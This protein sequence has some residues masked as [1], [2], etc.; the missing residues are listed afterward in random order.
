MY[1]KK[2][3]YLYNLVFQALEYISAHKKRDAA[4]AAAGGGAG[5]SSNGH[6]DDDDDELRP[7]DDAIESL[8]LPTPSFPARFWHH[9]C[10]L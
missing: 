2:V 1:S 8:F 7:L 5:G 9:N 10:V 6:H 4:A 3:E